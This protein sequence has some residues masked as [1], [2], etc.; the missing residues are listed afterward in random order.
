MFRRR[1][2]ATAYGAII[3]HGPGTRVPAVLRMLVCCAAASAWSDGDVERLTVNVHRAIPHDT[4]AFTQGLLWADGKLY[5]STGRRG[6]SELRE[7]DPDT[8]RVAR[9]LPISRM[10]FGEG[11]AHH[12]G[13]LVMLTWHA[14][15]AYVFATDDFNR[16]DVQTYRGEGWGLCHDGE[17]F[18]MSDGSDRLTFRNSDSFA[19][20]GS[21]AVTLDGRP[22]AN[23]NELECVDGSI[24][25]N[26]FQSDSLVRIDPA[27]GQVTQLIDASGLLA[28]DQAASADVLNG[29]AFNPD[30]GRFTI[31]GKLWPLMFEVTFE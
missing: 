19:A 27:R 29:I 15:R 28:R 13:R 21:V 30:S 18:V 31:T 24:Y 4:E 26:V 8:G 14:E 23:I 5:E 16:L 10:H 17:R 11:L 9:R 22:V 20:T 6:R 2:E 1:E 25:A 12:A 3:M 7:L